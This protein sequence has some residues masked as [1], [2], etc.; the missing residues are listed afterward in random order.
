MEEKKIYP[1]RR[2]LDGVYLRVERNGRWYNICF[3]DLTTEERD[4]YLERLSPVGIK[5][6]VHILADTIYGIGTQLG[7]VAEDD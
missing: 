4:E 7:V 5:R 2:D 1:I 3:S 6:L